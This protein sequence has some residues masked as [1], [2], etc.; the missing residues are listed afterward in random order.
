[1]N[2]EYDIYPALGIRK[3]RSVAKQWSAVS[4]E[5]GV[6]RPTAAGRRERPSNFSSIFSHIL[7]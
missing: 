2:T 3:A 5:P 1:M 6:A 7:L 4:A